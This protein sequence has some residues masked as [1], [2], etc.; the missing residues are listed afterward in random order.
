MSEILTPDLCIIGAGAGG[1]ALAKGA[2]AL[3][4]KVVLVEK[5]RLGGQRLNTSCIPSK[6]LIAA[7]TAA[8]QMQRG[9][10]FGISAVDQHVNYSVVRNHIASAMAQRAPYDAKARLTGLG[11]RVIEA[12]GRFINKDTCSAGTYLI[13]ASKFVV[14]TG[15]S[16]IIPVIPGLEMIRYLTTDTLFDEEIIPKHLAI[17]GAGSRAIE[18]G[19]AYRRLGCE[20]TLIEQRQALGELDAELKDPALAAC[21]REGVVIRDASV[22]TRL[23]PRGLGLRAFVEG[24]D[25]KSTLDASHLLLAVGRQPN[26]HN[27]GFD[28]AG[29]PIKDGRIEVDA[30]LRTANKLIYAVGDV[31]GEGCFT[32]LAEYQAECVLT[33][34]RA[35]PPMT[36]L[37]RVVY[38]DPEIAEIG[39]SEAQAR[40]ERH[41]IAVYRWPMIEN[42]RAYVDGT[43]GGLIKIITQRNGVILGVGIVGEGAGEMLA[44]WSLALQRRLRLSDLADLRLPYP[45][46]SAI[47]HQAAL[48]VP[49][50]GP[51][52][53]AMMRLATLFKRAR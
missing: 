15:S 1:L 34:R 41:K 29:V 44:L 31:V 50:T 46:L 13:K 25:G 28:P 51:R 49:G 21:R 43:K 36:Y 9:A 39:L 30:R 33:G 40:A 6:A 7:A 14:A 26:V 10:E 5:H 42:D 52:P 22:I 53:S 24:P 38:S 12:A 19:Q 37:P 11:V 20:V 45:S 8:H 35:Q 17:L 4:L 47:A 32:H 48:Q 23:E 27:L 16:P 3:G 2:A 18:I